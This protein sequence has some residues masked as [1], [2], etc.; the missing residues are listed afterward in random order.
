MH[1]PPNHADN[2]WALVAN[3]HFHDFDEFAQSIRGW[4]VDFYQLK[5]GCSLVDLLQ[6]GS[7]RF[8][9]TRF[10]M[11][12][13]YDQ[14]GSTPPGMLT[15]GFI[16]KG[17]GIVRTPEGTVTDDEMWCFSAGREFACA[18]EADFRA[19][20]LSLSESLL[21]E[22]ANVCEL[23]DVRSTMGSNRIVRCR[24]RV[25]LDRIRNR[26]IRISCDIRS[27]ETTMRYP[28]QMH[29]LELD[30][31]RQML[32]ALAGPL[33]VMQ[34]QMSNRRRLVLR[35]T[36]DYLEANPY[37]PV[38]VHELAQIVGCGIRTLE[39]V[40]RDYFGTTPKAYLT[41][42]RL[43]GARRELQRSD[44]ESTRVGDIALRWGFWHLG[45]FSTGYRQFFGELPSQ[46]LE[47][48]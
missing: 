22:V 37:S 30:L 31:A 12:Q 14:R 42:R 38:T 46:T 41:T 28:Q 21:D 48:N 25:E 40:F 35:R 39:Y 13:P 47:K 24:Q 36:L 5:P 2:N 9:V 26:L 15:L 8:L 34:F 45:R 17:A 7:P 3:G 4:G 44:A 18:S 16:E 29:E 32:E 6:F 1:P 11:N 19:Y 20:G 10:Q 33:D 23:W 27:G 43:I